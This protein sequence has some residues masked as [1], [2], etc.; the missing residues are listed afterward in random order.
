ML[1][2]HSNV[3]SDGSLLAA[4]VTLRGSTDLRGK[5]SGKEKGTFDSLA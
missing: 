3:M 1:S 4:R 5:K 2:L